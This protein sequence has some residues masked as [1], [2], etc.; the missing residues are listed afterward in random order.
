MILQER[1]REERIKWVGT[2]PVTFAEFLDLDGHESHVELVDGVLEE[3]MAVQLDHEK[4]LRWIDHVLTPY[5]E[6]LNLGIVLGSRTAVE[7][8][9]FRGRLPDLLFVRRD[10]MAIVQQKAVCGAPDLILEV[11]SP[12]DRPSDVTALEIDYRSIGVAEIVFVAP[13][14]HEVRFLRKRQNEYVE[15]IVT[16]GTIVLESL[17]DLRLETNWLFVEP[18]PELRVT[19]DA[20]LAQTGATITEDTN[21]SGAAPIG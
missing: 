8:H 11:I 9:E 21:E 10:R 2:R 15:E 14:R 5:V 18:R 1:I 4:L 3:R 17:G 12:N 6:V 19:V 20:L 16:A 7:I 13:R